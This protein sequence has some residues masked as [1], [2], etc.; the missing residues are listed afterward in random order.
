MALVE[1]VKVEP[2]AVQEK[3]EEVEFVWGK[4]RGTGGKKKE[5]QFYE[6]F[7][8]DGVE[9]SLYDRVYMHKEGEL[10][11]I[12]MIIKIWENPDK[13]RKIKIHWF[14]RPSEILYHL[15][16]VKVA[17]NE[18]FLASGEG[19]GLANVNHLEAI[20]GK[21]NVVCISEDNRNLQPSDEEVKMADYV[22][23][24]AFDVGNCTIV[25]KMDDKV[26]GLDV[27]CVFNRKESQKASHVLK[28]ASD[29]KDVET[30]VDCRANGESFGL[31]PQNYLATAK[32]SYLIGKSDVDAQRSLVR[33]DALQRDTNVLRVNQETAKKE[34]SVPR[35][36][37]SHDLGIAKAAG[38][39]SHS[40]GR[41][42]ADAKSSPFREDA[43][44]GDA[45]DSHIEQQSTMKGNAAAVPFVNSKTA[46][47]KQN[48]LSEENAHG[49]VKND[50]ND[51]KVNKPPVQ[52]VEA[53]ESGKPSKDLGIL[54]DR[55][56][57]RIKV[58]GS[59]TLLEDKGG[60]S[61]QKTT[62]CRNDKKVTGTSA[63]PSEDRKKSGDSMKIR[64]DS[65]ALDIRPPK[66]AN[67]D[68][69]KVKVD[70]DKSNMS[71][72]KPVDNIGKLPKLS[73]G[74]SPKE[75]ERTEGK[76]FEVTR[77]PL[78]ESSKWFKS[79]PWEEVMQTSN[80]QGTLILLENLNP[81]Y[82]SGE[83]ED[84]IWHACR[85]NCT[86]K[87]V[88]RTAF[89]SPYSGRA[90]V[91]FKTRE[92][93]ERVSKKLADGCLMV[94]NQR[95]LVASFVTLPKMEGNTPSF[96]GH[97][98]VDKLRLQLQRE[99]KGAVSTSHC[100]Q[101]NT[102][103]HEMGNEWRLLQARSDNWWNRLYKQQKEE[104]RKTASELKRK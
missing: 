17:E 27:Q 34:N 81:D 8:Y 6:S 73:V 62:V 2:P 20:A 52:L 83:V 72:G 18:V 4:K 78:A 79:P 15:K 11:Y 37:N 58:N 71:I 56:S 23:Y 33:Q 94:S 59:V 29:S 31:K 99:M 32:A 85:E 28:L 7:T 100:S 98:F 64:K 54:D 25:D 16:D 46:T 24:R 91:A 5:V 84:I 103:E 30:A 66:K 102:I 21:C 1:A 68:I 93:A 75:V 60:N 86:A 49:I 51:K 65:A 55:P 61:V 69:L 101:P 57:K 12:G 38:K 3:D 45:N 63:A 40:V 67:I 70:R 44:P 47:T 22:F 77:R 41:S 92:A 80:E 50:K 9:Y 35:E 10:P 36:K 88:Q 42:D 82:T 13:S 87:M 74:T 76:R 43:F 48:T 96:A 89:S 95:P 90:L 97:L 19:T 26:G 39:S 104:I 14:F 53:G